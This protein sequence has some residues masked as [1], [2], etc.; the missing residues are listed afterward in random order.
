[1]LGKEAG[2]KNPDG[3]YRVGVKRQKLSTHRVVWFLL[4]GDWPFCIDHIDGNQANNSPE[5]LR[6]VT[7]SENQHNRI[8]MGVKYDARRDMYSAR[9][10]VSGKRIELGSFRVR[11]KP[12]RHT[13]P[14][15]E[16]FTHLLLLAVTS[17]KTPLNGIISPSESES[18][19]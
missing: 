12:L 9:I 7:L 17:E 6:P 11:V 8:C 14:Q 2:V 3:Y 5:N 13:R 19:Q 1:M 4:N 15:K 16:N 10:T 18:K